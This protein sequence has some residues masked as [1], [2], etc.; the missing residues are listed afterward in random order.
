MLVKI[1]YL[2]LYHTAKTP[3]TRYRV[4][5]TANRTCIKYRMY[6]LTRMENRNW[7]LNED[8]A[9]IV[10][11]WTSS[12]RS[13]SNCH[14]THALGRVHPK[15]LNKG[16]H[17]YILRSSCVFQSGDVKAFNR[18]R[19]S[20]AR[21]KRQM[22]NGLTHQFISSIQ[23]TPLFQNLGLITLNGENIQKGDPPK[24]L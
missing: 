19:L 24:K 14:W 9:W 4:T 8:T 5:K 10:C 23:F 11:N 18:K 15:S 16:A 6:F 21:K 17:I 22:I 20:R 7:D 12:S 13:S 2:H 1:T 3:R